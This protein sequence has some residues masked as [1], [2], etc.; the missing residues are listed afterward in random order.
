MPPL[1]RQSQTISK[2]R[3]TVTDLG[4]VTGR[5]ETS[6]RGRSKE[7]AMQRRWMAMI[8]TAPNVVWGTGAVDAL[9]CGVARGG[10]GLTCPGN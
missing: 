7:S 6:M 9:S 4:I 3:T 10:T 5:Y 1:K 2:N 8:V